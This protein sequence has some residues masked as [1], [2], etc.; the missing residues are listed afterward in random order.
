MPE[1]IMLKILSQVNIR[2]LFGCAFV[3]KRMSRIA[4]DKTLWEKMNLR[5]NVDVPALLFA[6]L[7]ENGCEYLAVPNSIYIYTVS[8]C[9]D[10]DCLSVKG[11]ARFEANS[12]LKYLS[13]KA[14]KSNE[15]L[16]DFAASCHGLEKLNV[17]FGFSDFSNAEFQSAFDKLLKCIT[18]SSSTLKSLSIICYSRTN[19]GRIS[20]ESMRLIV[21][22]CQGLTELKISCNGISKETMMFLCENLTIGI[23]K[24]HISGLKTFG[25]E[26]LEKLVTRCNKLTELAAFDDYHP[27]R[28]FRFSDESVDI[29]IQNLSQTLTKL[30]VF[31]ASDFSF[32][33]LLKIASMPNFKVLRISR[34]LP[35]I[36]KEKLIKMLPH[37]SDTFE[38]HCVRPTN[39]TG[40][41]R[42][43]D[44]LWIAYPYQSCGHWQNGFW[45]IEA[46]LRSYS[47]ASSPPRQLPWLIFET[48]MN[49]LAGL[50][51][52]IYSFFYQA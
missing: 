26:Q 4:K 10:L 13:F 23:E 33:N 42:P 8:N 16:L 11:T 32:P 27:S 22:T 5:S 41:C 24:L 28:D 43:C 19:L 36:E 15:G 34:Y 51:K 31:P 35:T 40:F 44:N 21:S 50:K 38:S 39:V 9:S 7:I 48:L 30:Q 17:E 49:S 47:G 1:E 3:S 37:L 29:T 2:D 18:N 25:D 20:Y 6:K 12:K 14:T 52:K 45:E 46:K